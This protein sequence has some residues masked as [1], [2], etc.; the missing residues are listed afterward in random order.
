MCIYVHTT[1]V[2]VIVAAPPVGLW[3]RG[4]NTDGTARRRR[5]VRFS[6]FGLKAAETIAMLFRWM[7]PKEEGT[8]NLRR[9]LRN[10]WELPGKISEYWGLL[11]YLPPST[12]ALTTFL[13]QAA[14]E[15]KQGDNDVE[16]I[17]KYIHT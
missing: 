9:T 17:N 6:C 11:S 8:G 4:Q 5:R 10:P 14:G 15:M 16:A 1:I 2:F 13:N 12:T 3:L 7:G